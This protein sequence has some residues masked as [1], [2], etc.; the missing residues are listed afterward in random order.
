MLE[1]WV[2]GL[3]WPRLAELGRAILA[4]APL[5]G[6]I[7]RWLALL[8]WFDGS[9]NMPDRQDRTGSVSRRTLA[10]VVAAVIVILAILTWGPGS[11]THVASNPG[12]SGTPGSTTPDP[13]PPP[14]D[15]PSGNT[16]GSAR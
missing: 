10:A 8:H 2:P 4:M 7:A 12:P 9:L 1:V 15:G 11:T 13:V 6:T 14:A 3:P 5:P 16:T